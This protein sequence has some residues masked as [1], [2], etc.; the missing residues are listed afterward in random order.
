MQIDPP[1]HSLKV[2]PKSSENNQSDTEV[3][4]FWNKNTQFAVKTTKWLIET[5]NQQTKGGGRNSWI[6]EGF[7]ARVICDFCLSSSFLQRNGGCG[8]GESN[9]I[10]RKQSPLRSSDFIYLSYK[11]TYSVIK[12]P[13][14]YLAEFRGYKLVLFKKLWM[15]T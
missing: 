2:T 15:H 12:A 5:G 14:L 8:L 9:R 10:N 1:K 7:P 6:A 4:C 13:M 3:I 11:T